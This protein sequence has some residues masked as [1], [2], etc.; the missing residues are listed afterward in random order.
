MTGTPRKLSPD[1]EFSYPA[2]IIRVLDVF[3]MYVGDLDVR[4]PNCID[5]LYA[6][7]SIWILKN[8][9]QIGFL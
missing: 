3:T 4:G 1:P 5:N 9:V 2:F 6:D 7:V 8:L